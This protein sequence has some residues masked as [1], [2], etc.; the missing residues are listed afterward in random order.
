[1]N[2]ARRFRTARFGRTRGVLRSLLTAALAAA[3]VFG[4]IANAR[5]GLINDVPSCYAATHIRPSGKPYDTLLYIVLDQSVKL[6]RALEQ[7]VV[8]NALR[9]VQPG[10]KFV[11]AE[12]SA[13]SQGRY[14]RVLHTGIVERPLARS[15]VDS[16]SIEAARRLKQCLAMQDGFARRMVATTLAKVMIASTSSLDQSDIMLAMKT[17]ST[18]VAA[19]PAKRKVVFVVTDG[20]ENSSITSFYAHD[21]VRDIDPSAEMDKATAAQMFGNFGGAS[22]YVLGGAMMPP[23]AEGTRDERDGYRDPRTLQDLKQFW[24]KYFAK[25]DA[26]LIEFGEPALIQ[27]VRY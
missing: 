5:A 27:P 8:D 23:T 21:S 11:I 19:D 14:L 15:Q 22:I 1:M 7:S 20:L 2:T 4:M 24:R 6:D 18:A 26:H 12:F 17:V 16:T 3:T 9:L 13:F 10:S 25:S